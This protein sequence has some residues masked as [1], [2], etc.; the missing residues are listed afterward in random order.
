MRKNPLIA[1]W[2]AAVGC[3]C[4]L[5]YVESQDVQVWCN[6]EWAGI[7]L[8]KGGYRSW[9]MRFCD[10]HAPI[11]GKWQPVVVTTN[12]LRRGYFYW[13]QFGHCDVRKL[14]ITQ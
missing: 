13:P 11:N 10:G 1:A 12:G 2:V 6:E 8:R 3:I 4:W 5:G 7:A 14:G 9:T